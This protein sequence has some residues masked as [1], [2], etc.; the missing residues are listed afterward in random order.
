MIVEELTTVMLVFELVAEVAV[1]YAILPAAVSIVL[2]EEVIESTIG[3]VYELLSLTTR[4]V[5][6]LPSIELVG[7]GCCS[8][9]E[10]SET[11]AFIVVIDAAEF[12]TELE[13]IVTEVIELASVQLEVADGPSTFV[14]SATASEVL[15]VTLLSVVASVLESVIF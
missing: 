10:P 4:E 9:F 5:E 8:A 12:D 13:M 15:L 7:F 6:T 14:V 1:A 3:V 2:E 11:D